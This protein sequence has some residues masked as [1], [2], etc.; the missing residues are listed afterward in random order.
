MA[1][2]SR[3]SALTTGLI[4]IVFGVI[5]L[6][7]NLYAPFSAWRL[8]ARY[9]PVILII[10]GARKLCLHWMWTQQP[11]S[12]VEA[13]AAEPAPAGGRRPSLLSALLWLGLGILCLLNNLDLVPDFWLLA[14]RY[15]PVLLI[16]LGLGKVMDYFL[17][18]DSIAIRVGELIGIVLLVAA[19]TVLT[20]LHTTQMGQI[21]RD[22]QLHIGNAPVRPGQW[23][24]NSHAFTEDAV[25]PVEA[26]TP[27]RIRNAHGAVSVQAGQEGE[28]RV[29]LK[30]TIYAGESNARSFAAK[31][32]LQTAREA[33]AARPNSPIAGAAKSREP[34]KDVFVLST[35]RDA[36]GTSEHFFNT[37]LEI[38]VPKNSR[39]QVQNIFGEVRVAGIRGNLDLSTTQREL[40][41]RDCMG[42]FTL[43]TRYA[44]CRL[45]NLT[46]NV[47]LDA[48]GG[49][50]AENIQGDM[51]VANEYSPV[52]LRRIA[53][54]ASVSN[55]DGRI[56][57]EHISRPVTVNA[58]GS[59]VRVHGLQERLTLHLRHTTADISDLASGATIESRYATLNLKN[60]RGSV[61]IQSNSDRVDI[62]SLQGALKMRARAS[63]ARIH[64]IQGEADIQ[65]SLKDV[66]IDGLEGDCTVTNEYA[67]IRI[68]AR[69]VTRLVQAKNRSGKIDLSLPETASF[70]IVASA[71]NGD[72]KT[73]DSRLPAVVKEGA[74][75]VLRTKTRS[76][77]PKILLETEY[78]NIRIS[79]NS[80]AMRD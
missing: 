56:R 59:Q 13:A 61:D 58:R 32:R 2:P 25:Y 8:I 12:P 71:R 66:R 53:G 14:A 7:E 26:G 52:D 3:S 73:D 42:D 31:I 74:A 6:A 72:V 22:F 17:R 62:D 51:R 30:K 39:V 29:R 69:K 9:W 63:S 34:E 37:D 64:K 46:G 67:D 4:L 28:I 43:F 16:L 23:V 35:N 68:A 20:T 44:D 77:D 75:Q 41:V 5:F 38:Y 80:A 21:F 55:T 18:K 19:G 36:L 50:W 45:A 79:R 40:A 33:A 65:T 47:N 76:G 15:W 60:I 24:G 78:G 54:T 48:R 11:P 1:R 49:V 27:I 57:L 70:G 10:I